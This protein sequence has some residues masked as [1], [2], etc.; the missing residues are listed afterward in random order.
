MIYHV[1]T[2]IDYKWV[3]RREGSSRAARRF[4]TRRQCVAYV[5]GLKGWTELVIHRT[6]GTVSGIYYP[7]P[8]PVLLPKLKRETLAGLM[9]KRHRRART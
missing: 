5:R 2:D 6:D 1:H 8:M 7:K 9:V 4:M 3:A